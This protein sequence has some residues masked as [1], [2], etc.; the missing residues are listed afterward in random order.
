MTVFLAGPRAMA[1]AAGAGCVFIGLLHATKLFLGHTDM[2]V[3][4][5]TWS[6][7]LDLIYFVNVDGVNYVY[8]FVIAESQLIAIIL[9]INAH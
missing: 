2:P 7:F 4:D 6:S 8:T 3:L 1:I 9:L 5:F